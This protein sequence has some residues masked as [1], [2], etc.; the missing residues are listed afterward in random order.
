MMKKSW[1]PDDDEE[2]GW[3]PMESDV[4]SPQDYDVVMNFLEN[5]DQVVGWGIEAIM[6]MTGASCKKSAVQAIIDY[7]QIIKNGGI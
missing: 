6:K 5:N 1:T 7:L 4:P 3:M 2:A